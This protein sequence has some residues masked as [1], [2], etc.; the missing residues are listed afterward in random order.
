M[1][2][3]RTDRPPVDTDL[4]LRARGSWDRLDNATRRALED[5]ASTVDPTIRERTSA[6]ID[7]VRRTGDAALIDMARRFDGAT[8]ETL[9]VPR[10]EWDRA[11]AALDPALRQS[12]E[13]AA[14]N[15]ATVHRA[16]LPTITR[17]TPEPGITVVRRPD[18][19]GRVGIYAPGG[20]AAYPSSLLM[21]AVPARVAGVGEIIVCTPP[22]PD[23]RPAD[24]VL[25]A[26]ALANVDRVFAVGGAGAIAAMALGTASVP[27]VDRIMGPGNAYVAEAKLQLVSAVAIDA[28]AGPSE[29]LVL[30][31]ASA[32]AN[33]IAREM[34]AQAEHDPDAAVLAVIVDHSATSSL[35]TRVE[36]AL[37]TQ[38][39]SA[40]RADVMRAALGARGGVVHMTS[41][42]EAIT[43]ANRWAAEH[44][45]LL[46][47]DTQRDRVLA[48]LRN[49]GT[50][51]VGASS[52]VAFGDYMTGANHVLP[53]AGAARSYSGLS[54]LDFVRWTTW[55]EVTPA[56]AAS[57]SADV[58]R[59]ADAEG[60]PAHAAT[61]RTW[62]T[63]TPVVPANT[64]PPAASADRA[65]M[66][67][68]VTDRLRFARALYDDVPLYDPKR[69]PVSLDLTDNTNLW[70]MPPV[71]EHT[72]RSMPVARVTRY[73]SLY[74]AELKEALA[75][76]AG[77]S[78]DRLVTGC[79]SDDILDSAMR[80]FGEPGSVVASSEP[81]FAMI[82]IF[83][84]MNGLRYVGIAER[85][86]QQPDLDALLA[87][88]PRIL[89]LCSPNNPTG[90]VLARE[91]LERAVREAPGVVFLDEA[92][93]EFAGVSAVD[94]AMRVDNLL[95][96]RTMSKAFGL[97]GL[98]VGYGIGAPALVRDV[99]KSRGPYKLNAMAEQTALAAL[100]HDMAWVREHVALAVQNRERLAQALVQRGYTPLPSHAN[101]LCV[102]VSNAVAVGQAMRARGVAARPF[103]ALPHVGDTLRISVG[104]WPLLEQLLT[105]F[106]DATQEV[107][108]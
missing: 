49:A 88:N 92:Y 33:T 41:M 67:D 47:D 23:G 55:Q 103:P 13:R 63:A 87:A 83:A 1:T 44:L 82:P 70:G 22:G 66:P 79:G 35:A 39:A 24:V 96:I 37:Q 18:P 17:S 76:F 59:F 50:I 51:F 102:P 9:E 29:L 108:G 16:F 84:R 104:P 74:A 27:R 94:L 71:A 105:A 52:S 93:A 68:A 97:A 31:D 69:A 3:M 54:T 80:A 106:D 7:A 91:L 21:G 75:T 25:A 90:A 101:Y 40:P 14:R 78:P 100:Q 26:A 48:A 77:A 60:L 57:L 62:Q 34:L 73:P 38:L 12:L 36:T 10:A 15:I 85:A 107:N 5:R 6:V 81:S 89:Y 72:W 95:V 53:T 64:Q 30:A 20:R 46:V 43:F 56:A 86:D 98:R 61:A 11:L 2:T 4:P 8:L 58:G 32:D 65:Q 28:P 99:E 19:L 42:D 45:L